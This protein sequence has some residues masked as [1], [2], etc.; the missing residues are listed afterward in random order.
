M[1][2]HT[3]QDFELQHDQTEPS[4]EENEAHAGEMDLGMIDYEEQPQHYHQVEKVGL[5]FEEV[6]IQI[7]LSSSVKQPRKN[8]GFAEASSSPQ[9]DTRFPHGLFPLLT[10]RSDFISHLESRRDTDLSQLDENS[11]PSGNA[12][13]Q[14]DFEGC[15]DLEGDANALIDLLCEDDKEMGENDHSTSQMGQDAAPGTS[16]EDESMLEVSTAQSTE[17]SSQSMTTH[18]SSTPLLSCTRTTVT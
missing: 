9:V 16:N 7:T 18:P 3:E 15:P 13:E 2:H 12:E 8:S 11:G 10:I 5:A 4:S 14:G 6:L 1:S 17:S